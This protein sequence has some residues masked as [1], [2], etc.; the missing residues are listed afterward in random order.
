MTSQQELL[1]AF[2]PTSEA[3]DAN[4]GRCATSIFNSPDFGPALHHQSMRHVII[5]VHDTS[6][7]HGSVETGDF[8]GLF[9]DHLG[10]HYYINPPLYMPWC[11]C[12]YTTYLFDS[13]ALSFVFTI[14][15]F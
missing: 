15:I 10:M 14:R 8:K 4:C 6:F 11:S 13:S 7:S 3:E 12:F 9:S 5:S 1:A 2:D